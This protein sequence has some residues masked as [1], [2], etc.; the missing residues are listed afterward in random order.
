VVRIYSSLPTRGTAATQG[1]AIRRGIELA[2]TQ[3]NYRAARWRVEYVALEAS[4]TESGDWT[5]KSE[6]E[7]ARLAA[8]DPSAIAYIG[9]YTS[10]AT[11][12]SLPITNRAN[13]LQIG[14]SA[15]W[16]GLTKE[17][18]NEGEPG[19][20]FPTGKRNYARLMPPDSAQ[21]ELAAGWA[22]SVGAR[23]ILVLTDGSSYSNG[24][25][26]TFAGRARARGRTVVGP[27][28][29]EPLGSANFALILD[30][31]KADTIF[32]A[33]S[34][35]GEAVAFGRRVPAGPE[36]PEEVR[37]L[38][39]DTALSDKLLNEQE[40]DLSGW[41]IVYN[42][43]PLDALDA[44]T[45]SFSDLFREKYG[46][47]PSLQAANAYDA[48][49][50]V[51]DAAASW[52]RDRSQICDRVLATQQYRGASGE[53]SFDPYGDRMHYAMSGYRV[54]QDRFVFDRILTVSR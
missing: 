37:L 12:V 26:A 45:R 5:P 50:L 9:P 18:W 35:V 34:S 13:L 17:G 16:P 4:A 8:A 53:I 49:N 31:A 23:S 21:G 20:H 33:P 41:R 46:V 48:A 6:R 7:N 14:V 42:G 44:A 38:L 47:A 40:I 25:A 19:V 24:L 30:G 11:A 43:L 1:E 52:G 29:F 27:T 39:S 3:Q 54:E 10:G 22:E 32:Y 28:R 51:L 36:P 2:L 15:T